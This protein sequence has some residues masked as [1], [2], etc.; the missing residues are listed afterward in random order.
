MDFWTTVAE[1]LNFVEG[2][3]QTIPVD[4]EIYKSEIVNFYLRWDFNSFFLSL[5]SHNRS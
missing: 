1:G 2:Q 3:R 5:A 4:L